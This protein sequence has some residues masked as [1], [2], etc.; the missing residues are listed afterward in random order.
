MDTLS[1]TVIGQDLFNLVEEKFLL[2]GINQANRVNKGMLGNLKMLTYEFDL[3]EDD[4]I[5]IR[6]QFLKLVGEDSLRMIPWFE[7]GSWMDILVVK[8]FA[9]RAIRAQNNSHNR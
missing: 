2:V 3:N 9:S 4:I 6:K 7:A 5:G 8:P 1:V